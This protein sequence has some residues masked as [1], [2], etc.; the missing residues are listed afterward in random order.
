MDWDQLIEEG[1]A[2]RDDGARRRAAGSARAA[3][4]AIVASRAAFLREDWGRVQ[5]C[6][7]EAMEFATRA[8]AESEGVS[9]FMECSIE[10]SCTTGREVFGHVAETTLT[11]VGHSRTA[12][13]EN[14]KDLEPYLT[15]LSHSIM[16]SCEYVTLVESYLSV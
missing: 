5:E 8:L 4:S 7:R 12:I 10:F 9:L 16:A 13:P 11:K 3:W 14:A 1:V 2:C 15:R 6:L